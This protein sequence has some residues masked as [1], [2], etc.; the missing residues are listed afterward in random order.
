MILRHIHHLFGGKNCQ[1]L[2][3]NYEKKLTQALTE[4]VESLFK[5]GGKDT[6]LSIR[7]LLR[8]ETEAAI[9]EFSTAVAGF[10]LDEETFDKMVQKVK[11]DATTVVERKAREEAGKVRIHMKDRFL[12]IFKYEHDSKPRS[13][14]LLSVMAAVRLDEK[15][16]KIENVLF[17]SLMDGTSPDPLASSTWEECRSLWGQFKADIEDTVAKAIPEPDANILTVFY[18]N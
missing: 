13:L 15:P 4:P 7:E 14:K 18:I 2:Q 3:V 17:S 12:T 11:G 1:K 5:I 10:E 6:W 9:S 16:D 8:R